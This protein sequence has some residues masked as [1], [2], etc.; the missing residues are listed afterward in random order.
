MRSLVLAPLFLSH[1]KSKGD[2][3]LPTRDSS[4]QFL[5]RVGSDGADMAVSDREG[6]DRQSAAVEWEW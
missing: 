5:P 1:A 2:S 4:L 6:H 3:R